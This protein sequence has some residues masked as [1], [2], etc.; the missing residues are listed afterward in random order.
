[1][2]SRIVEQALVVETGEGL[3]VVTGCAHPGV[4]EMVRRSVSFVADRA[5]EAVGSV[6]GQALHPYLVMGGFHLGSASSRRVE[7]IIADFRELGVQR[8]AP[9]HCTGDQARQMFASAFGV[10]ATLA[11]VGQVFVVG[12]GQ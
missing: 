9:C 12:G 6:G 3:V 4:V 8:V 2:G 1:M 7:T 5:G 11:G 10:D